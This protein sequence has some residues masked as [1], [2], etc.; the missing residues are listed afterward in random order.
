MLWNLWEENEFNHMGPTSLIQICDLRHW[1]L[2]YKLK[3]TVNNILT[4]QT[5]FVFCHILNILIII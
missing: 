4:V 3:C 2:N 5:R 1:L